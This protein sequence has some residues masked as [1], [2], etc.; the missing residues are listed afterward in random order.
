MNENE[1]FVGIDVSKDTLDACVLPGD[2]FRHVAYDE[3]GI[4]ALLEWFREKKP[5]LIVLEATGGLENRIVAELARAEFPVVVVNPRQTRNFAKAIGRLSKTDA[6]DAAVL[7]EF[8]SAVRP[9]LRPLRDED[10]QALD[11]LLTRRRQLV[12]MRVQETLRLGQARFRAQRKSLKEHIAWLEKR[13]T[14]IDDDLQK[15]LRESPL[16]R[17]KDDLLQSIPGIGS[18]VSMTMLA[19][20]PELGSLDRRQMAA[21]IGVAPMARDSGKFRGKRAIFGGRADVR[22]VLY[23]A[24]VTA[25]RLNPVI[26]TFADRLK[27]AG[28]PFKVVAVAC[29]RKLLTIMNSI[30]KH[31]I[32]WNPDFA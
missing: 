23:M 22:T 17:V 1:T 20:C 11:E 24:A 14:G 21:L 4:T 27:A 28:K 6:I 31:S 16:W 32:P 8:A 19:K 18:V 30:I 9:K 10:T 3:A 13:I 15:Q 29:M 7:A 25:M 5:A 2:D 26:K 12:D